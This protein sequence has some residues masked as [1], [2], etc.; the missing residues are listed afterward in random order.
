[1]DEFLLHLLVV[2]KLPLVGSMALLAALLG[3]KTAS[4]YGRNEFN[5]LVDVRDYYLH[6]MPQLDVGPLATPL[7]NV[8]GTLPSTGQQQFLGLTVDTLYIKNARW[9]F[10]LFGIT[11]AT[12]LGSSPR[13]VTS[14]DGS[15]VEMR[16]WT[17]GAATFLLPGVGVRANVRR[18]KLSMSVRAIASVVWLNAVVANG[19]VGINTGDKTDGST[20]SAATFGA[21]A[22]FEL[23]RRTDPVTRACLFVEPHLYEFGFMNGGSAGLRM[24][25]GP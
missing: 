15:I 22:S 25:F 13:V 9:E 11:A 10:P 3:E 21:R 23:C 20:I 7:R 12:A 14:L 6:A 5:V 19:N 1:L 4:A 2:R 8:Q 16:P 18:W 24:E 17:A